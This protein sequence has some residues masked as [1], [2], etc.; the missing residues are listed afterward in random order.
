LIP[1]LERPPKKDYTDPHKIPLLYSVKG[2][3]PVCAC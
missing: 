2:R 1:L 3:L